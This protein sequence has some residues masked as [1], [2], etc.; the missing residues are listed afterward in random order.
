M[1]LDVADTRAPRP[2][3]PSPDRPESY[4][5]PAWSPKGDRIAVVEQKR[6]I[7]NSS[8]WHS[9]TWAP[10]ATAHLFTEEIIWAPNGNTLALL[11]GARDRRGIAL[12]PAVPKMRAPAADARARAGAC[13]P[14]VWSPDSSTFAAT[15]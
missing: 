5:A 4:C 15:R 2:L 12:V 14:P 7:S 13:Q 10:L 1:I 6:S 8:T 9:A 3:T 11:Y